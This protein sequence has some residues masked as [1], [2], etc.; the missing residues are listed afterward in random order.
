MTTPTLSSHEITQMLRAWGDGDREALDKLLPLV[1][2]ELHRQA[3]RFLRH[4]RPN[5]TLQTTALIHEAYLKL[6]DQKQARWQNRAHFFAICAQLMRRILVDHARTRQRA[7]RGGG[8]LRV[9]L[10][11]VVASAHE[12]DINLIALD[13][14]LARL[15][16]LDARQSR[17]VELRFFGGLD[18]AETAAVLGLSPATIKSDW[19][20]AK[21]W[22]RRELT[23]GA[24]K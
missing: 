9:T 2:N 17:V 19:S 7:K 16:A 10:T 3:A 20:L 12:R 6:V 14:A 1:Y 24:R 21:A 4:E 13:E 15:A 11:E 22:L 18:V 8:D 23:R 5:H